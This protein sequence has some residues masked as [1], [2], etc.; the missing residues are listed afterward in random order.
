MLA[1]AL[2][3]SFTGV[4]AG[5]ING[6]PTLDLPL[7]AN[8]TN[9]LQYSGHFGNDPK[10]IF[11]DVFTFA[12]AANAGSNASASVLDMDLE[13]HGVINF[14]GATLNGIAFTQTGADRW[15]LAS[16]L[17]PSGMLTLT[18]WGDATNGGSY[19]GTINLLM[20]PSPVPEQQTYA[21]LLG[22]LALLGVV[23][24][25]RKQS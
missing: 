3:A 24:R 8:G 20:V 16:T 2:A 9:P 6:L 21:M 7:V 13:G 19:D 4:H 11:S 15:S 10:G 14:G 5:N 25:R 18:V 23:A 1:V 12:P 22:G 17:V